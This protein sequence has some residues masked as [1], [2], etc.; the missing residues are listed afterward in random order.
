[1]SR[2]FTSLAFISIL[3]LLTALFFGLRV[4]EYN[5]TYRRLLDLETELHA[6]RVSLNEAQVD[7]AHA[8]IDDVFQQLQQPR[9]RAR[10]HMMIGIIAS[11]VAILVNCISVTYF[12]GTT[13]WCKEVIETYELDA[14]KGEASVRLKRRSFPC[15][16]IG[17]LLVMAIVALGAASDPGTLRATT[18]QF[19]TPHL[20]MALTGTCLIAGSF[21]LQA[22]CIH[23]NTQIVDQIVSEVRQIRQQRGLDVE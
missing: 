9:E 2:I 15:S 13:R 22:L 11:L 17:G 6:N 18:D 21:L 14:A 20:V 12:V 8:E 5:E 16:C 3:L 23:Q 19:V 7:Q 1:M 10:L 4:G